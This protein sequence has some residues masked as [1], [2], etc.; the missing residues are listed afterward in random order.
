MW[1]V[2]PANLWRKLTPPAEDNTIRLAA[3]PFLLRRDNMVVVIEPGYGDRWEAKWQGIYHMERTSSLVASLAANGVKPEDVTH[4][5]A[6]HCHWDHIGSIVVL[7][8]G[9]LV[10]LFPNAKH[11]FPTIEVAMLKL[12]DHARKGSYRVE[13]LAAVEDEGLLETF[14][15]TAG[16]GEEGLEV[17]PGLVFHTLGGHSDGSSLLR[18]N[19]AGE[20]GADGGTDSAVF[21][22]DVVPTASHIQ[23][24]FIMAYDIDVVRSFEQRAKW[25]ARAS[26]GGW[27]NLFYHD[28]TDAAGRLSKPERRYVFAPE[29]GASD[30]DVAEP[31]ASGRDAVESDSTGATGPDVAAPG[32]ANA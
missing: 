17:L 4:V 24:A 21:W 23:P 26:E 27:L 2:V 5:L 14:D 28:D 12:Q 32:S 29:P 18:I 6:T 11:Q 19:P 13:D 16:D 7:R 8:D 15:A 25:L 20:A 9:E 3:R 10:P 22:G 31:I 30:P 1:G